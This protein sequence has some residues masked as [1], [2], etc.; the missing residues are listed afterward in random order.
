MM[1]PIKR[2]I[3]IETTNK[4]SLKCPS[5]I[6]QKVYGAAGKPI[7]PGDI[8]L[9]DFNMITDYFKEVHFSGNISDPTLHDDF[10][11][12]LNLC[13]EKN[14]RTFVHTAATARSY[15]W[16]MKA[17][18]I[19]KRGRITWIFGIDGLPEDSHKF[20]INQDGP[21]LYRVMQLCR[22]RGIDT[23][24]NCIAF[25]YNEHYIDTLKEMSEKIDVRFNLIV[26]TRWEEE[27][28]MINYRPKNPDL[29][30]KRNFKDYNHHNYGSQKI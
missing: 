19:S 16:Y 26:S 6:R 17:F 13:V 5:C 25:N 3:T 12:I 23:Q 30:R 28:G 11:S 20:R 7:P 27:T 24:W 15:S 9:K 14:I 29:W 2:P 4:C 8:S 21:K 18:D 10:H 1:Y 22:S